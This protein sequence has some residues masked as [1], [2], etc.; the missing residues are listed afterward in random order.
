MEL[1][2]LGIFAQ[3]NIL[4][5]YS[6]VCKFYFSNEMMLFVRSTSKWMSLMLLQ[7]WNCITYSTYYNQECFMVHGERRI[8][9]GWEFIN[10][11]IEVSRAWCY[12]NLS[13]VQGVNEGVAYLTAHGNTEYHGSDSSIHTYHFAKNSRLKKRYPHIS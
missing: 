7:Q 2:R 11:N 4:I 13:H 10:K 3:V 6:L 5:E 8:K 12:S 1:F 9:R